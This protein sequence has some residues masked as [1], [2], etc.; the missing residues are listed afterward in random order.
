VA[1][2]ALWQ[3]DDLGVMR[4]GHARITTS[5]ILTIENLRDKA[6]TPRIPFGS[7]CAGGNLCRGNGADAIRNAVIAPVAIA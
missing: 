3:L 7:T 6:S 1:I 2:A 4:S 5:A